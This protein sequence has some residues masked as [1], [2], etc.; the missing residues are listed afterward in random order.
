MNTSRCLILA[1]DPGAAEHNLQSMLSILETT[2]S[3]YQQET[4]V[5]TIKA[6]AHSSNHF[7]RMVF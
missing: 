6:L 7:T 5:Q 1:A 4:K 2:K 3:L